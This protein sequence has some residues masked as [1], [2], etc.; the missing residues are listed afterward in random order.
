MIK[1]WL[2]KRQ[3]KKAAKELAN[4]IQVVGKY[5]LSVVVIETKDGKDY[6]RYRDGSMRLIGKV[7]K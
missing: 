5:G 7:P 2:K 3:A 6:L 1:E 4:A